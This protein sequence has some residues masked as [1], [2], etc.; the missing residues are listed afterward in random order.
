LKGKK[1]RAKIDRSDAQR[2]RELLAAGGVPESWV[3]PPH[4]L[5]VR[6][7]GLLYIDMVDQRRQ[8]Q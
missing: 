8:W 7:L 1:K 3:P 6:T 2:L 4:V 5:E